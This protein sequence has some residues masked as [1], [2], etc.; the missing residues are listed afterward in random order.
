MRQQ[1]GSITGE[2]GRRGRNWAQRACMPTLSRDASAHAP[3]P[4]PVVRCRARLSFLSGG[5]SATRSMQMKC[6][7]LPVYEIRPRQ[8]A[9][10]MPCCSRCTHQGSAAK[11]HAAP[12][13][14][15]CREAD[16]VQLQALGFFAVASLRA[17]QAKVLHSGL[18]LIIALICEHPGWQS[19]QS[20]NGLSP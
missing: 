12:P 19:G 14:H 9:G 3:P 16:T 11:H 6:L 13:G 8:C 1:V 18:V 4:H 10:T 15:T 20:F 2:Q 17:R 5:T 7:Q